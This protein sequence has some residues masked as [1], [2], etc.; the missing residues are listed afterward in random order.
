MPAPKQPS[1]SAATAAVVRK[2]D[3]TAA[4]RLRAHG[5]I[6]IPPEMI[7]ELPADLVERVTKR[8]GAQHL[9][10]EKDM[11]ARVT[12][13]V[14]RPARVGRAGRDNVIPRIPLA[15]DDDSADFRDL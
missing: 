7:A 14:S 10:Q 3:E 13:F 5:W 6:L 11:R 9:G 15:G 2:G 4:V 8:G 12:Q 1:T